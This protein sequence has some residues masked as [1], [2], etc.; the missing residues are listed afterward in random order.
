MR[1]LHTRGAVARSRLAAAPWPTLFLALLAVL[2]APSPA[3]AA[4]AA[5]DLPVLA[6]LR[7]PVAEAAALPLWHA[8]SVLPSAAQTMAFAAGSVAVS[9]IFV[10]SDGSADRDREDWKRRDPRYPGDRRTNVLIQV[11]AALDWWSARS[12]DATLQLSMPAAGEYGAPRTVTTR[13]EPIT[14]PVGQFDFGPG[15]SDAGWRWQIMGKLGFKHDASDDSPPPER[16]YA[17]EVRRRNGTDWAFVLYVV[18]SLK[19]ADGMF[20]DGAVAYTA[21][22]F[23]PYTVLTY[24]NDGYGF[25]RFGAVLAHEMGHEFGALDEYAPPFA[26]YP[27][28]GGLFSGYLGVK[29]RNAVRG[30]TTDLPCIMRGSQETLDAFADGALC[31]STVGQTGFRASNRDMRPDVISTK[32]LFTPE[33]PV[34]VAG[35]V[36]TLGGTVREQ[37]WPHGVSTVGPPFTRDVSIF[38][39][40]DL[41]YRVDGGDWLPLTA[42]DGAF[43]RPTERWTFT[44]APLSPG[45][46]VLDVQGTTGLTAGFSLPVTAAP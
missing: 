30:G 25:A 44:T 39:P 21:D 11:Q 43:D 27:S 1:V 5:P 20:P 2:C 41:Q 8:R 32:P 17:D 22:L 33:Q 38:V 26:G 15:F 31:P 24:D 46:H 13:Y 16:A 14:R 10:E 34:A 9:V 42:E 36:F 23:G 37:P 18:D 28:T 3:P 4:P 19:D 6:D 35:G 7:G 45:Q 40:H 12:P 29:N